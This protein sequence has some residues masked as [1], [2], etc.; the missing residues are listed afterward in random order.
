MAAWHL[1]DLVFCM[2]SLAKLRC[3]P[4]PQGPRQAVRQSMMHWVSMSKHSVNHVQ[5]SRHLC[6]THSDFGGTCTLQPGRHSIPT[7]QIYTV[8]MTKEMCVLDL[9]LTA[10]GGDGSVMFWLVGQTE[11]LAKIETA[12]ENLI[13]ALAFH[14][15]GHMMTTCEFVDGLIQSMWQIKQTVACVRSMEDPTRLDSKLAL[16][17]QRALRSCGCWLG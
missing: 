10:A 15:M 2:G 4:N 3:Q 13:N 14:P 16:A 11:S 6:K 5:H 8:S 12:H 1:H 7:V 17:G 9:L